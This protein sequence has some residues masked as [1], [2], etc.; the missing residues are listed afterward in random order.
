[1]EAEQAQQ[2]VRE[3]VGR[4]NANWVKVGRTTYAP[5][6]LMCASFQWHQGD[7]K[8]TILVLPFTAPIHT[9]PAVAFPRGLTYTKGRTCG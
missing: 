7:T 2:V 5:G 1:M 8:P 4:I 9:N 3:I 6:R